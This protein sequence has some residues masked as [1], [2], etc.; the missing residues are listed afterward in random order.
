MRR[1]EQA[2]ERHMT[3][4]ET[5]EGVD[6]TVWEAAQILIRAH[7]GA[8]LAALSRRDWKA[9]EKHFAANVKLTEQHIRK[10]PTRVS[11]DEAIRAYV[12]IGA[13]EENR[14]NRHK[15]L[16]HYRRAKAIVAEAEDSIKDGKAAWVKLID[17]GIARCHPTGGP[18]D[19]GPG[20]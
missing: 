17:E 1:F 19:A 15:G 20:R 14:G 13:L 6:T 4:I 2:V 8:G 10:A 7:E 5:L 9:S 3:A 18:L 12:R 11:Y 16:L